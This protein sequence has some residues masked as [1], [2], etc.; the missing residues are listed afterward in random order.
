MQGRHGNE[1]RDEGYRNAYDRNKRRA[2]VKQKQDDH[3]AD[4]DRFLNQV[5]LECVNRR[6]DQPRAIVAGND[7]YAWRQA[8]PDFDE[9]CFDPVDDVQRILAVTH[10]H[11]TADGFPLP[12][13]F[14]DALPEVRTKADHPKITHQNRRAILAT[15]GYASQI[16]KGLD[17]AQ[18]ADQVAG[19]RHL[20]HASTN[21]IVAVANFI[22]DRLERHVQGEQPIWVELDLVLPD[23]AAD[24]S[25][26]S[27]SRYRF[28]LVPNVPILKSIQIGKIKIV[29]FVEQYVF[30]NPPGT[31][32]IRPD[33]RVDTRW[34]QPLELLH[35]FEYAAARPVKV[36]PVLENHKDIGVVEHSLRAYRFDVG[37]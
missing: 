10:H 6:V 31:G 33:N 16:I 22:D 14:R 20:Q 9:L 11:D 35:V 18:A 34:Q 37:R 25:D 24:A 26:L 21:L 12:V 7:L 3:Q 13:P 8:F 2:E 30:V 28:E 36:G 5:P 23:E 32:C 29:P 15:H 19:A 27:N 1:G 17:V 4:D